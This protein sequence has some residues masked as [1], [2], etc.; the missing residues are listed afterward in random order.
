MPMRCGRPSPPATRPRIRQV[1]RGIEQA[2]QIEQLFVDMVARAVPNNA[3][4][5]A[6]LQR[7][8]AAAAGTYRDLAGVLRDDIAPHARQRD[9]Y[10]LVSRAFLGAAVGLDET[11]EWGPRQLEGIVGEQESVAQFL[12]PGASVAE[13]LRR[14]DD[15]P[16][17]VVTGTD[18]LQAWMQDLSDRA[19]ES[20]AGTHFDIA[21][22]LRRLECRIA[23]TQTGGSTTPD[24]RR[25]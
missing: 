16:R 12:Y 2:G 9:A 25:T 17:Y 3:E 24:R 13:T 21:Q 8:A 6:E 1:M 18:A 11:Y 10:R 4:L 7:Q 19:V 15:E 22:P 5:H 20:L 23:P 14:L